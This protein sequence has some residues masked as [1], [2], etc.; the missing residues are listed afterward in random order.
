VTVIGLA[1]DRV[2]D[3]L[4]ADPPDQ[5]AAHRALATITAQSGRCGEIIDQLRLVP[6]PPRWGRWICARPLP[7]PWCWPRVRCATRT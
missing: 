2:R 7:A 1:A 6:M 4:A 5:A 3:A